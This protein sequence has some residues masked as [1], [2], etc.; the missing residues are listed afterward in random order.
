MYDLNQQPKMNLDGRDYVPLEFA[1]SQERKI[2]DL[3]QFIVDND[4]SLR[5]ILVDAKEDT[6]E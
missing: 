6:D 4:P 5:F 1:E 2:Y 3:I